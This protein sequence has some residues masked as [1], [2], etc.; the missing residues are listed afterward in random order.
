MFPK[1]TRKAADYVFKWLIKYRPNNG[2]ITS[3]I[4]SDSEDDEDMKEEDK[5]LRKDIKHKIC[6]YEL[7][8][9]MTLMSYA[10]EHNK[11]R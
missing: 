1:I 4:D 9:T 7:L 3:G 6:I 11:I 10:E 8:A 2:G 5:E